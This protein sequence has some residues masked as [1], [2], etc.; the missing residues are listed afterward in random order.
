[1]AIVGRVHYLHRREWCLPR[2][3]S[4]IEGAVVECPFA[5]S[6]LPEMCYQYGVFF[7]GVCEVID[8]SYEFTYDHLMTGGDQTCLWVLERSPR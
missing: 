4:S 2:E 3:D 1:M 8:P 5:Q 7:N 6:A